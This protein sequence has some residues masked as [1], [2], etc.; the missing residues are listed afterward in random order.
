MAIYKAVD[1]VEDVG[2]V[3]LGIILGKVE[4][5]PELVRGTVSPLVLGLTS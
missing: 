2:P 3:H 5:P 1:E 4:F